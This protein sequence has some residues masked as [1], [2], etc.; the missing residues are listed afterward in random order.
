MQCVGARRSNESVRDVLTVAGIVGVVAIGL[1]ALLWP[2]AWTDPSGQLEVLRGTAAL[3]GQGQSQFFLGE[4]TAVRARSS[5]SLVVPLRMTPWFFLLSIPA[6]VVSL[7]VRVL[8]RIRACGAR[9]RRGACDR[10]FSSRT[11][12]SSDTRSSSG[13]CSRC[14]VGLLVQHVAVR[15]QAAGPGRVRT[16]E[17]TAAGAVA[18]VF[19]YTLLV[20]P[21]GSAY[22]NPALGG[23]SVAEQVMLLDIGG[24]NATEAGL[25]IRDREGAHCN[26]RRIWAMPRP[27]LWF[28]CGDRDRTTDKLD[29]GD[30]VV[31]FDDF[32]KRRTPEAG[33]GA[34]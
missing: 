9:L 33:P 28:P 3:P 8:R 14:L 15:C 24:P 26:E 19:V 30:Y 12:S 22:T 34:A 23:A 29:R 20:A 4:M 1:M 32:T 25:F 31:L 6:L 13:R 17:A 21:H 7:R 27:R 18:G 5:T 11:R 2:A 16:F 10:R